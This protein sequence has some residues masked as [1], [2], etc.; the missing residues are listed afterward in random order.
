[1]G[2]TPLHGAADRFEMP[3]T[4]ILNTILAMLQ[5]LIEKGADLKS[6]NNKG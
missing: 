1:M 6:T 2:W 3:N 4:G 5:S